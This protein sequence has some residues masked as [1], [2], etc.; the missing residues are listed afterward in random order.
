[1]T[2]EEDEDCGWGRGARWAGTTPQLL[3][4]TGTL[5]SS[6]GKLCYWWVSCPIPLPLCYS[7]IP[8]EEEKNFWCLREEFLLEESTNCHHVHMHVHIFKHTYKFEHVHKVGGDLEFEE[9]EE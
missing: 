7:R 6:V 4:N 5:A 1:M 3:P 2:V 8:G 9:R